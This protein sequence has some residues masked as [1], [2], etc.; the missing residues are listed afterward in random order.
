[1]A[2]DIALPRAA[3]ARYNKRRGQVVV[4]LWTNRVE[5]MTP[6]ARLQGPTGELEVLRA[7]PQTSV[8]GKARW[9]VA[10]RGLTTREDADA[11]DP[12]RGGV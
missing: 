12:R 2:A 4:E 3:A 9:L 8:G 11:R 7:G 6:G 10:F 1:M 5:R